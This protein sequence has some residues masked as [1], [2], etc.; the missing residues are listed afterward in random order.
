VCLRKQSSGASIGVPS[1]LLHLTRSGLYVTSSN[2]ETSYDIVR[3]RVV[4]RQQLGKQVPAET[5][6]HATP[7]VVLE[8]VF[9]TRSVQRGHVEDI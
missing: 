4:P 6:T 2:K 8:T 3:C 1:N 5:R 7:E 9:S